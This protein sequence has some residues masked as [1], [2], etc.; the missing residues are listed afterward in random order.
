MS[1]I[2]GLR[3]PRAPSGICGFYPICSARK[4]LAMLLFYG[5]FIAG[6]FQLLPRGILLGTTVLADIH[7]RGSFVPTPAP[8]D[9]AGDDCLRRGTLSRESPLRPS[10]SPSPTGPC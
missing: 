5:R 7:F 4:V 10:P 3:A 8:R 1:K 9:H 6:P 2:S